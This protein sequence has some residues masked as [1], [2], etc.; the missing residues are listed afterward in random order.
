VSRYHA[1]K[2][3]TRRERIVFAVEAISFLIILLMAV[4]VIPMLGGQP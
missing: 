3:P 2:G 4:L 1:H